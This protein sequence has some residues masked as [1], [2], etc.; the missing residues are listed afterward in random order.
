MIDPSELSR[1]SMDLIASDARH[2]ARLAGRYSAEEVFEHLS[3]R[4]AEFQKGLAENEELGVKLA[5]YGEAAEIHVRQMAYSNP[6]LIEFGGVD[7]NGNEVVLVQHISQLNF[8]LTALKA[9][10]EKAFRIGFVASED[11]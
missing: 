6:N 8:L 10:E 9:V 5:N 1:R 2:K 7:T 3:E 4:M 11:G